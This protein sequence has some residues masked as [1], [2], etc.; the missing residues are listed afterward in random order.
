MMCEIPSNAILADRFLE[1]FDGFSI[2]SNDMTQLTLARRPRFGRR[3][4]DDVRRARRRGE[5]DAARW[6]SQAC[7]K[8]G[9]YVGICGQG[10]SD[11][12][13]LAQWLVEQR[14]ESM[15]LNPDTVVETWLALAKAQ[16]RQAAECRADASAIRPIDVALRLERAQSA[17]MNAAAPRSHRRS[18]R[19]ASPARSSSVA[20]CSLR[21]ALIALAAGHPA[22]LRAVRDRASAR[23]PCGR[24][25]AGALRSVRVARS[26]RL[27]AGAGSTRRAA[28]R[29]DG[30][31]V[32]GR[33]AAGLLRRRA[34]HDAS[35]CG[36]T[37]A[38][39]SRAFVPAA[40]HAARATISAACAC[41]FAL[42][43]LRRA[44]AARSAADRP[45][46]ACASM[47]P[48][49]SAFGWPASR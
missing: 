24:F 34:A 32:S 2:G 25:D 28:S 6:R 8:A 41:C 7:R 18:V 49:L 31:H 44:P 27:R 9:K 42:G 26:S 29:R 46:H 16:R 14:I 30:T 12:P 35:S 21:A 47:T 3:D 45:S 23:T 36:R 38:R 1:H 10:P 15:S 19:R 5:G 40:R 13:D 33:C 39:W 17:R 43:R 4:R 22:L 37:D 48:P 20:P 11:H